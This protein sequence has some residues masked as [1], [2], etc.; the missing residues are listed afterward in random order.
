MKKLIL[1]T[2]FVK[3]LRKFCQRDARIQAQVEKAL[4]LMEENIFAS[5]LNTHQLRGEYTGFYAC[6]CGY[7][8]RIIFTIRKQQDAEV[9]VLVNVGTHDEVY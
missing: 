5:K 1:T 4:D 3:A 9:I 8:C 6:S 2:K 7:D